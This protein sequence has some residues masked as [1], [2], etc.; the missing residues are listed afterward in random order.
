V[1][2]SKKPLIVAERNPPRL[3]FSTTPS[4]EAD[5][6]AQTNPEGKSILIVPILFR[7]KLGLIELR[8]NL[9]NHFD[10]TSQEVAF[11]L[12]NQAAIAL[13]NALQYEELIRQNTLLNRRIDLLAKLV[14]TN[15]SL[16]PDLP[17]ERS[18]AMIA[19]GFRIHRLTSS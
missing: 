17:L 14:E 9:A 18:L 4:M 8:S 16:Q 6:S 3:P 11:S 10:E 19:S 7:S 5:W 1:I 12:A 13:S 2:Q 15:Q